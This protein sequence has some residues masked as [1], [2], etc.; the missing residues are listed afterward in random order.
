MTAFSLES[1]QKPLFGEKKRKLAEYSKDSGS[2]AFSR[3][4]GTSG[5]AA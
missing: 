2:S 1:H 4:R 3:I 5:N